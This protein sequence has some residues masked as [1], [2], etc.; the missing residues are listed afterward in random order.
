MDQTQHYDMDDYGCSGP[1]TRRPKDVDFLYKYRPYYLPET[2]EVY[3]NRPMVSSLACTHH[4]S[5]T[6]RPSLGVEVPGLQ[7]NLGVSLLHDPYL[8]T[9]PET[10]LKDNAYSGNILPQ[11]TTNAYGTGSV[12]QQR[13][14]GIIQECEIS[15]I[16]QAGSETTL[17]PRQRY[18]ESIS[19]YGP[20]TDWR[21]S[22]SP[23]E[24]MSAFFT[25]ALSF[26][27]PESSTAYANCRN[28]SQGEYVSLYRPDE[29]DINLMLDW[30]FSG[31]KN[32][33]LRPTEESALSNRQLPAQDTRRVAPYNDRVDIPNLEQPKCRSSPRRSA[34]V[35]TPH[36]PV[37]VHAGEERANNG[38]TKK[39]RR[40]PRKA[41]PRKPR[42]L[43]KEGKAHAKAVRICLGGACAD[44]RKK[45]TKA[46]DFTG[47]EFGFNTLITVPSASTSYRRTCRWSRMI[48]GLQT[49]H[50]LSL[51]HRI[52]ALCPTTLCSIDHLRKPS[53]ATKT[54]TDVICEGSHTR[55][56]NNEQ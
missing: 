47:D 6:R 18:S 38:L 4:G 36:V 56:V 22:S 10:L 17:H 51:R 48:S 32:S 41:G 44:C 52:M 45:K 29:R 21:P 8:V 49:L 25:E 27:Y 11:C 1:G 5:H 23:T 37:T 7:P 50:G 9:I 19:P 35:N 2:R 20:N 55:L 46:R 33:F 3:E 12:S 42:T 30:T 34:T 16:M 43:T 54:L 26:P 53:L 14:H 24:Q 31:A 13:S 28:Y 15:D 39:R 40:K